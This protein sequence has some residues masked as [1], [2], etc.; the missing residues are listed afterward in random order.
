MGMMSINQHKAHDLYKSMSRRRIGGNTQEKL[1]QE[2]L[3]IEQVSNW[4]NAVYEHLDDKINL[5]DEKGQTELVTELRNMRAIFRDYEPRIGDDSERANARL[6]DLFYKVRDLPDKFAGKFQDYVRKLV[7]TVQTASI[8]GVE[9]I[10]EPEIEQA[11]KEEEPAKAGGEEEKPEEKGEE[12]FE[13]ILGLGGKETKELPAKES[14][15]KSKT[16]T[17]STINEAQMLIVGQDMDEVARILMDL[18]KRGIGQFTVG[19]LAA[20]HGYQKAQQVIA[21]AYRHNLIT[22]V[23]GGSY[24]LKNNQLLFRFI[25]EKKALAEAGTRKIGDMVSV[26]SGGN[27]YQAMVKTLL[28]GGKYKLSF[29][30]KAPEDEDAEREYEDDELGEE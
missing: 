18:A 7:D 27:K 6:E 16:K 29:G 23:A 24:R 30:D 5:A 2:A 12:D 25:K 26:V 11:P 3:S 1:M 4:F 10:P 14:K 21:E 15:G 13:D 19:R 8:E 20:E 28:P 22:P 17:K 9:E